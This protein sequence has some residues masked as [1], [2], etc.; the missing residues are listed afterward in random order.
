MGA[1]SCDCYSSLST[2]SL[3]AHLEVIT[4]AIK[5]IRCLF[6]AVPR[7]VVPPLKHPREAAFP[8]WSRLTCDSLQVELPLSAVCV[9][10][11]S[12]RLLLAQHFQQQF[13][14]GLPGLPVVLPEGKAKAGN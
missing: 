14:I 6:L 12:V 8:P 4:K 3:V 1:H 10:L 9:S 5:K 13:C 2:E 11:P 7:R